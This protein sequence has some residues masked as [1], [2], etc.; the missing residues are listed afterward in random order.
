MHIPCQNPKLF[1]KKTLASSGIQTRNLQGKYS[2][3][4]NWTNSVSDVPKYRSN[5]GVTSFENETPEEV[6]KKKLFTKPTWRE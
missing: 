5:I 6:A 1:R 2:G 4:C 3:H